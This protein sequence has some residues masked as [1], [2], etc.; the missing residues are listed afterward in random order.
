MAA[1]ANDPG[2]ASGVLA[3][4][5]CG[6]PSGTPR[7]SSLRLP[8]SLPGS[9]ASLTMVTRTD[10]WSALDAGRG[11]GSLG[12]EATMAKDTLTVTDNRTGRS[13][14]IPI[15]HGAIRAADLRPL[16]LVSYDPAFANTASCTSRITYIDGDAGVL[17]Y[18]GYPIEQLAEQSTFLETAYLLI[19]GELPSAE[20]LA[21]WTHN[22]TMHTIVHENVKQF[23]DGFR[24]DAHPMGM[25]VATVGALS[26]FYPD[27]KRVHDP[28]SRRVQT[29]R[30][31]A[32]MPTIAAFA[33]RH[34]IGQPYAYPDNELSYTG[35]FLAM[36]FKMT[37]LR[38]RPEP[39]LERAL[40]VLY[41][42]HADHEQNCS[43]SVMRSIGSSQVDPFSA[44]AGACAALYGRVHRGANEAVLRM[45]AEIGSVGNI[46][47]YLKRV[48]A[49]EVRLMGFGHRVY[50]NF[51]PRGKVIK[52]L[53]E[54]VFAVTGR[55]RLLDVAL[56]LER[57]AL[58]DDYFV[59]RKLYPNVDFYSGIMYEAMG[60]KPEMFTV[61]FAIPRTA[62]WLAQWQEMLTDPEQKIAR[63]RQV[64]IG[65]DTRSFVPIEQRGSGVVAR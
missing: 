52:R 51:D 56:E 50:R 64:W 3:P 38:Y 17:L 57:I 4:P 31:L 42:L 18:R 21:Q 33:H 61:L 36:M 55:S 28:E 2:A 49:G 27:A 39:V 46:P 32:K 20:R 63:P 23:M 29:H 12:R 16:G 11:V 24:Y 9:F 5:S 35:N 19:K 41:I 15:E 59:S 30:L 1:A 26:T 62:G 53:P 25:L 40:D 22:I 10:S 60:F 58:E 47:A 54:Q 14:E 34:A 43:T 37:E 7:R 48:K 45:L 44:L 65:H 13:C 6:V 8:L